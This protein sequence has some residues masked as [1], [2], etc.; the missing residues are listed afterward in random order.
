MWRRQSKYCYSE[1]KVINQERLT[2][3]HKV[4]SATL[5]YS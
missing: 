4:T 5:K 2:A 3:G 1:S